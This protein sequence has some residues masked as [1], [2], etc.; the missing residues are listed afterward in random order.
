MR[1]GTDATAFSTGNS[2][3]ENSIV[4][5]GIFSIDP[6]S[7][8]F[9]TLARDGADPNGG[10]S[11]LVVREIR[12]YESRSLLDEFSGQITITSDTSP[13]VVDFEPE[14]LIN[15]LQNRSSGNGIKAL[16]SAAVFG[17]SNNP[18][19]DATELSDETCFKT[20]EAELVA[21]DYKLVLGF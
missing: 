7:G 12:V 16:T 3:V 5:G 1:I 15:N 8:N 21:S 17:S 13:S 11:D 6:A 19:P 20:T 10:G 18:S 2:V 4:E 9:F 14:N